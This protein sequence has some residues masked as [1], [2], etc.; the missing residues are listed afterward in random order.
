MASKGRGRTVE[1]VDERVLGLDAAELG[2]LEDL[3]G[4]RR[5]SQERDGC[6]RRRFDASSQR[7]GRTVDVHRAPR[8]DGARTP[9]P[10]TP[11]I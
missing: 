7:H 4:R 11:Q 9:A 1:E 2:D 3:R 6:A 10:P 5:V 8:S